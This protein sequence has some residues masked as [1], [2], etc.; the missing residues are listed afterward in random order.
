MTAYADDLGFNQIRHSR[1]SGNR[2]ETGAFRE[3]LPAVAGMTSCC[4]GNDG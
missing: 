4:R 3:T 2:L 1:D